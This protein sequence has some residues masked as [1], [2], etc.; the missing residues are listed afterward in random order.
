MEHEQGTPYVI[1]AKILRCRPGE[2]AVPVWEII[3]LTGEVSIWQRHLIDGHVAAEIRSLSFISETAIQEYDEVKTTHIQ[4]T[5]KTIGS[6]RLVHVLSAV[7]GQRVWIPGPQGVHF[8]TKTSG[9]SFRR[10]TPRCSYEAAF[11]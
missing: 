4:I 8:L 9:S 3:D 6:R 5:G 10:E 11:M 1:R 7:S 2:K